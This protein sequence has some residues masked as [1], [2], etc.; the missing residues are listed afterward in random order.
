MGQ[1]VHLT[2]KQY[3]QFQII[4]RDCSYDVKTQQRFTL[5][6]KTRGTL[7]CQTNAINQLTD[8]EHVN[9]RAYDYT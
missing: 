2:P 9:Q 7:I 3:F 8:T 4:R 6:T 1:T 5:Y